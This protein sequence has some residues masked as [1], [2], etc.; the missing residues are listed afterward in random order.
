MWRNA[1]YGVPV[2]CSHDA[3]RNWCCPLQIPTFHEAV[4]T[5]RRHSISTYRW[6]QNNSMRVTS[7]HLN[8]VTHGK[9]WHVT[10]QKGVLD[11]PQSQ[12]PMDPPAP[13][14]HPVVQGQRHR[15][16]V[17]TGHRNTLL[18]RQLGD[19]DGTGVLVGVS[20]PQLWIRILT[21]LGS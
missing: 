13:G 16:V 20:L 10:W 9:S 5:K 4:L 8:D 7:R 21:T 2:C 15:V 11:V 17:S 19:V 6:R 12:L 3:F 14:P 18:T 1:K